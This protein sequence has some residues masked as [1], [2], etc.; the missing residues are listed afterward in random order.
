MKLTNIVIRSLAVVVGLAGGIAGSMVFGLGL[1]YSNI[2]WVV[3]GLFTTLFSCILFVMGL[4]LKKRMSNYYNEIS[5]PDIH[6]VCPRCGGTYLMSSTDFF[7]LK[8]SMFIV[9]AG[10]DIAGLLMHPY[11]NPQAHDMIIAGSVL[12][13]SAF[14][15]LMTNIEEWFNHF[16]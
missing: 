3:L 5:S 2:T 9:G 1:I 7:T 8:A 14:V 6:F 12:C 15:F 16:K 11:T 10:L 13:F 4:L